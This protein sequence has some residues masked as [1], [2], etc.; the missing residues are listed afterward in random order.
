MQI[1][2]VLPKSA[3]AWR[4]SVPADEPLITNAGDSEECASAALKSTEILADADEMTPTHSVG[5]VLSAS[6]TIDLAA[7]PDARYSAVSRDLTGKRLLSLELFAPNENDAAAT[8][9]PG[10]SNPYPFLGTG[11]D[12]E[13]LPGGRLLIDYRPDADG[14]A[15]DAADR[16]PAVAA[17]VKEIDV[18]LSGTDTLRWHAV[19]GD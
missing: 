3:E 9:A 5:S 17:G 12:V 2:L 7:A 16:P 15:P 18:T 11:N 1:R 14:V 8:I 19:F 6:A 13:I 10:A 4:R